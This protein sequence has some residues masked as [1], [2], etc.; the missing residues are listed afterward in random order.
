M[1]LQEDSYFGQLSIQTKTQK[2]K[3]NISHAVYSVP[4][5][6]PQPQYI[7]Q[8][9]RMMKVRIKEHEKSCLGYLTEIQPDPT[10]DNG[11]PYHHA[12]TGHNFL[13]DQTKILAV[14]I[15]AF[16]RKIIV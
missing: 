15:Y 5:E 4:C 11:I 10:N 12:T 3:W 9:K 16:K 8:T 1:C 7:G 6:D 13:F 2:D 14:E